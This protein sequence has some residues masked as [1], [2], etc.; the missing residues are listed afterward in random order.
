MSTKVVVVDDDPGVL[1]LL[2]DLVGLSGLEAKGFLCPCDALAYLEANGADLV[3]TDYRMPRL[4]GLELAREVRR[5]RGD[6]PILLLSGQAHESVL[7]EAAAAG[8]V[9]AV[10][11]KPF[12]FGLLEE[13][14]KGLV[15]EPCR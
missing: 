4:N 9:T 5:L 11:G 1:S 12:D 8:S 14:I 2:I 6:V 7:K 13:K 10:L 15:A 3:L